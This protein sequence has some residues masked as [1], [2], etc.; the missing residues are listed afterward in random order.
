MQAHKLVRSVLALAATVIAIPLLA[1]SSAN[2]NLN[3][4]REGFTDVATNSDFV[5]AV[6]PEGGSATNTWY[7]Y[8]NNVNASQ[9]LALCYR[10][11]VNGGVWKAPN[12]NNWA[13]PAEGGNTT[14]PAAGASICEG[15]VGVGNDGY[16]FQFLAN[17]TT[18]GQRITYCAKEYTKFSNIGWQ[19]SAIPERCQT[20]AVD[21]GNPT[22]SV[23]ILTDGEDVSTT[24]D[25]ASSVINIGYSDAVSPPTFRTDTG[26]FGNNF[27]CT[28][29]ASPCNNGNTFVFSSGCSVGSQSLSQ[30]FSCQFGVPP[31]DGT[32]WSC[33][34]VHDGGELDAAPNNLGFNPLTTTQ[35][36]FPQNT[37]SSIACDSLTVDRAAPDTFIDSGPSEGGT[38]SDN[39]PQFTFSGSGGATAYEC[40]VDGAGFTPCSSPYTTGTLSNASHTFRVRAR[41]AAGNVDAT[42]AQRNFSVNAG[43]G[44]DITPPQTTI[45][46]G[47]ANGSTISDTTP[48]FEF[49]SNEAG[50]FQCSVDGGGFSGCTS[51]RTLGPLAEGEHSFQVRAVDTA[52]NIDAT[53]AIRTFTVDTEAEIPP[54]DTF[55]SSGPAQGSTTADRTPTFAFTAVTPSDFKCSVD[56]GAFAS[57]TS[58]HTTAELADDEHT[59]SVRATNANGETDPTPASRT[60]TVQGD[61]SDTTPPETTIDK[62]PKKKT[63]SKKAKFEFSSSEAGSSFVCKLDKGDFKS[64]TSPFSEAVKKGKHTFS[65]RAIDAADN[66]DATPAVHKWTVKKKKKKK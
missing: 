62:A 53:P 57:C 48:T 14:L 43:G 8:F 9:D 13:A 20:I 25:P 2:A 10:Y 35:T 47:P 32:Y 60:F 55:I 51:P 59:F 36:Y 16:A 54:P 12:G 40:S 58:P 15:P 46:A 5:W 1:P 65:V 24:N 30:T 6:K 63:K 56:G 50:T 31:N 23:Q 66:A 33:F 18:Q 41:D 52:N 17:L 37:N 28:N 45:T 29:T 64:C 61:D 27:A 4:Y 26:F 22:S 44:G 7:W 42:P 21:S 49:T 38:T 19:Q 3:E 11:N 34:R 39:T